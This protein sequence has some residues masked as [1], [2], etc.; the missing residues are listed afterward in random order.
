MPER[1]PDTERHGGPGSSHQNRQDPS[2]S[3]ATGHKGGGGTE[4]PEPGSSTNSRN[5]R[6]S[7]GGGER[8]RHHVHDT[9]EKS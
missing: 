8:D 5:S 7:G 9:T 6:I 3:A 4:G 1:D 2:K